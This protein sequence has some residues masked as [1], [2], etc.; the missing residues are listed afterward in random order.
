MNPLGIYGMS[1][2]LAEEKVLLNHPKALMVRTSAFFGP[3]DD[4]NFVARAV[5]SLMKK[6]EFPAAQDQCISPT[7]VPD[8]ANACLDLLIDGEYGIWN[9][10]NPC[11]VTWADFAIQAANILGYDSKLVVPLASKKM[12]FL[13][14]RPTYS[15]LGSNRGIFLPTLEDGLQKFQHQ[16]QLANEASS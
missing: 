16:Y 3:W 12:N 2:K 8:L 13:A 15:A 7:Y 11:E 1:K 10:T 5:Q 4:G 9:I 14:R 6:E